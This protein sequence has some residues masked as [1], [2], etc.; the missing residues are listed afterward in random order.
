M[1]VGN[2]NHDVGQDGKM[3]LEASRSQVDAMINLMMT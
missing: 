1:D 2:T 3:D